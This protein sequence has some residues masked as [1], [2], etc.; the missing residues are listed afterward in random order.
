MT[1][2]RRVKELYQNLTIKIDED[3]FPNRIFW[4][5][6][7]KVIFEYH[8][9]SGYFYCN[10]GLVWSVFESEFGLNYDQI[11]ELIKGRM[12]EHFKLKDVTPDERPEVGS[13]TVEEHFKL[14]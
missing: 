10:Y 8:K 6:N 13:S 7:D 11:S 14:K 3:K 9:K 4:I 12:E 2:E 5:R 1:P